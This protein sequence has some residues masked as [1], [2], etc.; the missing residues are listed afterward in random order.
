MAYF[1]HAF[2]KMM[3]GVPT[4]GTLTVATTGTSTALLTAGQLGFIDAKTNLAVAAP[5]M[6][7]NPMIYLAQGSFAT[8]DKLGPF[9]GGFQ[10]SIK[11]KGINPKYVTRF[12]KE[13]ARLSQN[14]ILTLDA[15]PFE[16]GKTYYLRLDVKGSPA[17]R[18]LSHNI[19][20]TF[21]AY[22]GCCT[23]DCSATCTGDP[24]DP[25]CVMGEWAK[26]I[27]ERPF[28]KDFVRATVT[29][30]DSPVDL[31]TYICETDPTA[32]AE[33]ATTA[34]LVL[35]VAYM[36]TQ[37]GNCSFEPMDHV[38]KQPLLIIPTL[39][40]ETGDPCISQSLTF[41]PTQEGLQATGL[42][43]TV[44]REY[45]LSQ[46]Y[47]ANLD[48]KRDPRLREVLD[49]NTIFTAVNR[50][51]SG[52]TVIGNLYDRYCILHSVPRF[53]N[54]SGTFDNDQYLITIAVPAGTTTTGFVQAFED[55]LSGA[56]N[57]VVMETFGA[58]V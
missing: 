21:D 27:N 2:Q 24:V 17:L 18:F 43:E 29:I 37:F 52:E 41:T 22:S 25:V 46:T 49:G 11:S 4:T 19:Y 55:Y 14:E 20:R 54:P 26:Q 12:Y 33:L 38:E 50:S 10:E 35:E 58:C 16:C 53:N 15:L 9:H 40:D 39:R 45:I 48:Y 30:S 42:G 57:P 23:N 5:N 51:N 6:S 8:K 56:G 47:G 36:D 13:C 3:I 34:K 7:A 31:T 32:I 28:M 44:I 1:S